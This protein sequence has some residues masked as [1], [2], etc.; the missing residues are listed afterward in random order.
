MNFE[1]I[2]TPDTSVLLGVANGGIIAAI[3]SGYLPPLAMVRTADAH[4][5]DIDAT[6]KAAAWT[7]AGFL[8]FMFLLTRDRNSFLIGGL[9]LVG[10]DYT[11]KHTNGTDPQTGK[12]A[13]SQAQIGYDDTSNNVY[14]LPDYQSVDDI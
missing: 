3:Y 12:L 1:S 8:A 6:R 14:S 7:S 13:H 11:V 10:I 9:V 5:S 2:L 4:D